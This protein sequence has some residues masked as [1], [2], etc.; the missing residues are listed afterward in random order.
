MGVELG[1]EG[2]VDKTGRNYPG[3][4]LLHKVYYDVRPQINTS[5]KNN[6][7]SS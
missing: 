1:G 6:L 4:M 7:K 3:I 2:N 5:E